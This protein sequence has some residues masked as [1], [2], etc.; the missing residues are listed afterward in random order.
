MKKTVQSWKKRL[1]IDAGII[2]FAV[3]LIFAKIFYNWA[4]PLGDFDTVHPVPKL[5]DNTLPI[6]PEKQTEHH[7][8]GLHAISSVY[9]SYGLDP[10][11]R[12]LRQRLGIDNPSLAYDS[13]TTGCL[14]PDIYRVIAQDGFD[15]KCLNLADSTSKELLK[16]HLDQ[17]FYA[18]A[19]IKRR[20]NGH[21]HW[22]VISGRSGN[23]ILICDSLKPELY[24]EDIDDYWDKCL[25]SVILLQPAESKSQLSL[26][27]LHA[28]GMKDMYAA[29]HRK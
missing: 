10:K 22:V 15:F 3:C 29:F 26:W 12:R 17:K 14:H 5:A 24:P 1:I 25:L 13:T 23:S 18:L 7:T 21:L 27:R 28:I 6:A 2:A 20:E 4:V 19:L 8:C 11:E 9:R 16:K